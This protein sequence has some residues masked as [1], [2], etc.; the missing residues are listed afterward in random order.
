MSPTLHERYKNSS[1]TCEILIKI[2]H[3]INI[4][5]VLRKPQDVSHSGKVLMI[6]A[7]RV[8]RFG[9]VLRNL[10]IGRV[11]CSSPLIGQA[12]TWHLQNGDSLYL[13]GKYTPEAT[14]SILIPPLQVSKDGNS[15]STS[16]Q[17]TKIKE[18]VHG[19]PQNLASSVFNFF[20]CIK[21][22]PLIVIHSSIVPRTF[23][24][25]GSIGFFFY[26]FLFIFFYKRNLPWAPSF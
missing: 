19:K 1:T 4:I 14:L 26:F 24:T 13:K 10:E 6:I 23:I 17:L 11:A 22:S 21:G 12:S 5:Y 25:S 3:C 18:L 7:I 16:Y 8:L 9:H 20:S 2:T 15:Y